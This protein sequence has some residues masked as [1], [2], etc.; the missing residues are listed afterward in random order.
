MTQFELLTDWLSSGEKSLRVRDISAALDFFRRC[1]VK[2]PT[3]PAGWLGLGRA[4]LAQGDL[5]QAVA[6]LERARQ[7]G[8]PSGKATRL[9]FLA[10]A[11]RGRPKRCAALLADISGASFLES[12]DALGWAL[13]QHQRSAI[14][15]WLLPLS[16]PFSAEGRRLLPVTLYL[17]LLWP[18][19]AMYRLATRVLWAT[20][21]RTRLEVIIRDR[22]RFLGSADPLNLE[23]LAS[24]LLVTQEPGGCEAVAREAEG[25]FPRRA[26]FPLLAGHARSV[27]G[28]FEAAAEHCGRA[29]QKSG[30]QWLSRLHL[31]AALVF[32][33]KAGEAKKEFDKAAQLH[34]HPPIVDFLARM[35]LSLLAALPASTC[36]AA[37][38]GVSPQ[39]IVQS[40][41]PAFSPGGQPWTPTPRWE[42]LVEAVSLRSSRKRHAP[43][44]KQRR[45]ASCPVCEGTRVDPFL[46][47]LATG[48]P[49]GRC[50]RCGHRFAWPMPSAESLAALY[51]PAYFAGKDLYA[52][53]VEELHAA[54]KPLPSEP[55]Y[56]DCFRWLASVDG[57]RWENERG[58]DRT[59]LDIGCASG[60]C[61]IALRNRGWA[62]RGQDIGGDYKA[63]YEKLGIPYEQTAVDKLSLEEAS[64]DLCTMLH[65][66]EHLAELAATLKQMARWLKPGGR[67][68][69]M[70]P[71]GDTVVAWLG[72]KPWYFMSEHVQ[73][74]TLGSLLELGRR[75]GLKVLYWRTR[76]GAEVETP[77]RAWRRSRIGGALQRLL[78]SLGQGDVIEIV[79]EKG[80]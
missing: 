39:A 18:T 64:L 56:E 15:R 52:R 75:C 77:F 57:E 40:D 30:G 53:R 26:V 44:A 50:S 5:E 66:V 42:Q 72:G 71:I 25:R 49:L 1:T 65:V 35:P 48:L 23:R 78:E 21:R 8:E 27:Q 76:V 13:R 31:G 54:G 33:G 2:A 59:A 55:I 12:Y 19:R 9:L 24:L 45:A 14:S 22:R 17:M 79:M 47:N 3:H 68:L 51:D 36:I 73:F 11:V 38:G 62:V 63:Y 6:H 80:P 46:K 69:V 32:Q 29:V 70:T 34:D 37:R 20:R 16:F 58:E 4:C 60:A 67:L 74:F 43:L 61:L 7:E 28:E 10:E 41:I